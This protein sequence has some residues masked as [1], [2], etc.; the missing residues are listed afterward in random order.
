MMN[1]PQPALFE[2]MIKQLPSPWQDGTLRRKIYEENK[3]SGRCIVA[4][5][6]DP[7]GTQTVHDIWV[8]TSWDDESIRLALADNEPALYFLTNSRSMPFVDAQDI[9]REIVTNLLCVA[10]EIRRP[11]TLVSR[12]DS[13]LRG[14]FPGETDTIQQ[15]LEEKF[16]RR[17]DGVCLIPYFAEGG[18]FTIDDVHWV[19]ENGVL[20]PAAQTPYAK[21]IVFGY[22]RS[23]LPDWIEEKTGGRVK[24]GDVASLSLDILRLGGPDKV[25]ECLMKTQGGKVL[26]VNA[27]EDRD[28]EVFV[29]ALLRA[30]EQGK[31]FLLRTA[32]SLV[33]IAAGL[34]DKP[35]LT[36]D[37]LFPDEPGYPGLI[38]FGSHV[39]KSTAQ[40]E[41]IK[42]LDRIRSIELPVRG[43]L[44]PTTRS[45]VLEETTRAVSSALREGLDA[46]L[47]TSR[48]LISGEN[49]ME[50][51]AIGR[52]V[53]SA[54]V[55]VLN[56]LEVNPGYVIGKGGITA[57]DLAT[58]SMQVRAAR[59]MGQI[60]PGVPV[61][62]LGPGSRWPGLVYVVFP[63]NVGDEGAVARVIQR[64]RE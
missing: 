9:N 27:V 13:T 59:V 30:E 29:S 18:R 11:I 34:P 17:V 62:K 5:D 3:E 28:L 33:K 53:S 52:S 47:F 43:V 58:Q 57:S 19:L 12:S 8:L 22:N 14:H 63:G 25:Y 42:S 15:T 56:R 16:H 40:L 54:L 32:A 26:I 20:I 35:L 31:T 37:E 2:D 36:R 6:D 24:P 46:V 49:E 50:S 48:E 60:L 7:T 21:D 39:P 61:W 41:E 1:E 51:L 55:E 64:M 38:V 10:Q 4:L 44:C 45:R 23:Y